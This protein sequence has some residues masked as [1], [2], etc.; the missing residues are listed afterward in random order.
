MCCGPDCSSVQ[1]QLWPGYSWWFAVLNF[2]MCS[3]VVSLLEQ[4]FGKN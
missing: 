2:S 3:C 4:L 1:Q